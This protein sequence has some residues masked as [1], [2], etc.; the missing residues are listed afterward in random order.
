MSQQTVT[1]RIV[2]EN[3]KLVA[4]VR[5]SKAELVSLGKAAEATGKQAGVGAAGI[6]KT[7]IAAE[8]TGRKA[9]TAKPAVDGLGKA[10]ADTGVKSVAG[11]RGVD[12]I[13]AAAERTGRRMSLLGGTLGQIKGLIAGYAGLQGISA[14]V[15]S[16]DTYSD[17]V[18]KLKQVT[19]G[20]IELGNAKAKTF[21]IAQKYYQQLDSTVTLY[22]RS[23][24]ALEEYG[25]NQAK[26]AKLT[27]TVSA[28]LLLDRATVQE[29][30]SAVLQLSQALGAG[31]LRGEEFNA[32]NEAAPS[33]MR[34]LAQ[35]MGRPRSELKK[36][37]E[38]G[39]LTIDRLVAAFTGPR[40]ALLMAEASKAPLTIGRAWQQ[41]KNDMTRYF[42]GADQ[43][44][45]TSTVV[46]N[47]IALIGRHLATIVTLSLT[48]AGIWAAGKLRAGV[49]LA[50]D[51]FKAARTSTIAYAAANNVANLSVARL[52]IGMSAS[53]LGAARLTTAQ[54]AAAAASR[55]LAAALAFVGGVP[56]L[57]VTGL[58]LLVGSLLLAGDTSEQTADQMASSFR[59]AKQALDAFNKTPTEG[60][61][62]DLIDANIIANI[63]DAKT[64]LEDLRQKASD[65]SEAYSRSLAR[66]SFGDA[67]QL[68]AVQE[69]G[70]AYAGQK[71]RVD[72]LSASYDQ[73][74]G[75]TAA[76]IEKM[77]GVASATPAAREA[78]AEFAKTVLASGNDLDT[79][80]PQILEHIRLTYGVEAA[81]RA[82]ASGYAEMRAQ[83]GAG[84]FIKKMNEQLGKEQVRLRTAEQ[85]KRAGSRL[86]FGQVVLS[87]Q[88][89]AGGKLS[90]TQLAGMF[91]AWQ[92]VADGADRADAAVKAAA[93]SQK[94]ATAATRDHAKATRDATRDDN[95]AAQATRALN[96]LIRN[97]QNEY[98]G[99]VKKAANEYA[100]A[101]QRIQYVQDNLTKATRLDADALAQLQTART[102]AS[103][104][105]DRNVAL[106]QREE[107]A[108]LR[109]QDL[110]AQAVN[111]YN[112][113][114]RAVAASAREHAVQEAV[115]R[116]EDAAREQYRRGQRQSIDL[117]L[118][119]TAAIR[120]GIEAGYG[121]REIAEQAAGAAQEYRR[122]WL[123]AVQSVSAA[124]GDWMTGGISSFKDFGRELKN[125]A[126]RF[127]SDMIRQF[128]N[129][130]I[131]PAVSKWMRQ[132]GSA[133]AQT[134]GSGGLMRAL[135]GS[136]QSGTQGGGFW[137]AV[138]NVFTSNSG[139]QQASGYATASTGMGAVGSIGNFGNNLGGFTG[140]GAS[141]GSGYGGMGMGSGGLLQ[142][143]AP[144]MPLAGAAYG[145]YYGFTE[146]GSGGASSLAAGISYGALGYAAGTIAAGAIGG[147]AAAGA[148]TAGAGAFATGSAVAGG[149]A[150]GGMTAAMAIPIVGWVIAALAIID[151]ASGGKVF[152]SKFKTT[153]ATTDVNFGPEG[154]SGTFSQSQER[155]QSL[156]RGRK[157]RTITSGVSAEA[158]AEID[159]VFGS[160]RDA[161]VGAATEIGIDVPDMV[162]A[163]FRQG[164]DR[165]GN[166]VDEFGTIAGRVYKEAQEVFLKRLVAE[167]ILQVAKAVGAGA[168][169]DALAEQY[170]GTPETLTDFASLMLAVQA[171]IKNARNLWSASGQGVLTD[172]IGLVERLGKGSESLVDTYARLTSNAQAYGNL[173]AGVDTQLLTAD[174]NQYQRGQLDI[175]LGYRDQV[176]QANA[177]AKALGL[178]GARAEDLA[179]IEQLRALGMANLQKQMEAQKNTFLDDLGL[180][181]L[182][183]LRDDQKL[184]ES[185]QLLRDAVGAGDLQRAQGLSQTALG[186][187]RNL[188]ASGN[189][190]S[191]L[192]GE[193]TGLLE[194]MT[195]AGMEGFTGT[196]LKDL[197]DI[198]TGLPKDF[199]TALFDL[200]F[201]P[202]AAPI[203]ALPP[204]PI[205]PPPPGLTPGRPGRPAL[206]PG[207]DGTYVMLAQISAQLA[208]I[209]GNTGGSLQQQRSDS[210][211]TMNR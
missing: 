107:Q 137:N 18:G 109:K 98:A 206:G 87:A 126:K 191:G 5:T 203:T 7:G 20:E 138:K 198:L 152:G 202:A 6:D 172:V 17:I 146:R 44:A 56:G 156:F 67:N 63:N 26:V 130:S 114:T 36:L 205:A 108:L 9:R 16:V 133:A 47:G 185:M 34:L 79:L 64:A 149:A 76:M 182:S 66:A 142:A 33:L 12:Q 101:L 83:A 183:P 184:V 73:A 151:L 21:A 58:A 110:V 22:A 90:Q 89:E 177:L 132:Y 38:D 93:E 65:A 41:A 131:M 68:K 155:Q 51:A 24:R 195:P 163:S 113:E 35:S 192:Y 69:V 94:A 53:T 81:T 50:V 60:R 127:M 209:D 181:D 193:V 92:A 120:E 128:T 57:I 166:L 3:G 188:Y 28:G 104:A 176:K 199:A 118:E 175:E 103:K 208:S 125:I 112:D 45:G 52:S 29:S 168:E 171:D 96:D 27:E 167:N 105:N 49:L 145:A 129:N 1:L 179:K 169:I 165:K 139:A 80:R 97:Q 173:I 61:F 2:G 102:E 23:S 196:D 59:S 144:A 170:R 174:L 14:L 71:L 8:R 124:F 122:S 143:A 161:V 154:A 46:A 160:I 117:T 40:A 158:Q 55:V 75:N 74:I 180:S 106:A 85:G 211:A 10:A 32:V 88:K 157:F 70:V 207:D 150:A 100:E 159:K 147:A 190:Y 42:G 116:A 43:S 78:T 140:A 111:D 48:L 194:G 19:T 72:A 86:E 134:D 37:A 200:L 162:A 84:D 115:L 153:S 91:N 141:T 123:G 39:E 210:L 204:P 136:G 187:G 11:A 25:F 201:A 197:A 178:S 77:T 95:A 135:F 31:A 13:G 148:A 54:L 4:S 186:L 30:A 121:Q 189:D 99:P 15:R 62:N 164:F 82:A 119:E